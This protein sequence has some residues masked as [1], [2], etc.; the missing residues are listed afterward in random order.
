MKKYAI[1]FSGGVNYNSNAPRYKNDL[2]FAYSVLVD[3]CGFCEDEIDVLYA[4]GR[5]LSYNGEYVP[6]KVA[7]KKNFESVL[8]EKKRVL[9]KDDT[10]LILV[11]N[12]GE[13]E[14]GGIIYVWGESAE[15]IS[16]AELAASLDMIDSR[17]ILLLGQCY[18]GNI[19]DYEIHNACVITAN[20]KGLPS[21]TNPFNGKYDEFFYHFLS[22]IHGSYPDGKQLADVGENDIDKAF[23][24]AVKM[25]VFAPGNPIGEKINVGQIDKIIEIPQKKCDIEGALIL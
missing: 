15:C 8:S 12:H 25:D 4:N 9:E 23:Q 2:E 21:Y 19:L 10:L 5:S 16:L 18:A 6:T 14:N 3:D 22:F 7:S 13:E 17:K 20:M 1:L 24:Y 11:S